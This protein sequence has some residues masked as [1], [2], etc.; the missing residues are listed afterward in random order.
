MMRALSIISASAVG[1]LAAQR[2][3]PA[4]R[5]P[6]RPGEKGQRGSNSE[7]SGRSA[8]N[9]AGSAKISPSISGHAAKGRSRKGALRRSYPRKRSEGVGE[10]KLKAEDLSRCRARERDAQMHS[11]ALAPVL[12][13]SLGSRPTE[14][15]QIPVL[16]PVPGGEEE[17]PRP[18][19]QPLQ[20]HEQLQSILDGQV[21]KDLDVTREHSL[22]IS[23]K[24]L[25]A[26]IARSM[27]HDHHGVRPR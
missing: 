3:A 24:A 20:V 18:G 7:R 25:A 27:A 9:A 10:T 11:H 5:V 8:V 15:I 2:G 19:L 22:S 13:G 14:G 12:L 6:A 1:R 23:V 26:N 17:E 21:L 4:A 16:F